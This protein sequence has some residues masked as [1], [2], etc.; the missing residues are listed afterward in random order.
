[1]QTQVSDH[2]S[3]H[4]SIRRQFLII[5]IIILCAGCSNSLQNNRP[6]LLVFA[7]SS[8]TNSM[9]EIE[10]EYEK[11]NS[12]EI[13]I[14]YAGSSTLARQLLH[15]ANAELFISANREWANAVEQ[16]KEVLQ[17][18]EKLSNQLVVITH[19]DANYEP[20]TLSDLV[21]ARIHRIAIA[22]PEG[23][24]A[25]IYAKQILIAEG[26]WHQLNNKFI[27]GHD[28]RHT[29]AQVENGGAEVG[30]VYLTDELIS[31]ST[32]VSLKINHQEVADIS[33]PILLLKSSK[34]NDVESRNFYEFLN[35][36]RALNIFRKHGFMI[37]GEA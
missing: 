23:V 15:G 4:L 1:M 13:S 36:A 20:H 26:L 7:A 34:N 35:S 17:R 16:Q 12:V 19:H 29:M 6:S 11:L 21:N 8:L 30:I 2:L 14:N 10:E 22:N 32:K 27:L 3:P 25:G 9:K 5:L 31:P 24:P 37:R 28:V 18:S 33:Y